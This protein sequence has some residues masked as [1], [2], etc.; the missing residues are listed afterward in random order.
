MIQSLKLS[1]IRTDA[2]TQSRVCITEDVVTDY[3]ARMDI[4]DVF[5]PV[6]VFQDKDNYYL[7]DGFHRVNAAMLRDA[8]SIDADIRQGELLKAIE[9]ACGANQ[10]NGLRRTN[11]DKRRSVMLALQHFA[12]LS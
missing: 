12:N 11:G 10:Q 4:G 3:A 2:G 1:L 8:D 7:A 5:P 6:I 9:Y